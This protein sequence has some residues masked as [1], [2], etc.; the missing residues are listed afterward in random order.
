VTTSGTPSSSE[1]SFV[2]CKGNLDISDPANWTAVGS[3]FW[4][5]SSYPP[6]P[7]PVLTTI[8]KLLVSRR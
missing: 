7:P 3:S 5:N 6:G 1:A 8:S 2:S 4:E